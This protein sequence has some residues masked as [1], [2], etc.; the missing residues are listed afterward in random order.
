MN[1]VVR[2]DWNAFN[3]IHSLNSRDAFQKLT[4]QLFC[5]EYDQPYGIYRFYNQPYIETVPISH[6]KETIG[7]QSKYY[8]ASTTLSSKKNDLIDAIS[9]AH[10]EYP[11]L[12][13]IVFYLNK[14]PGTSKSRLQLKPK[15][16]SEIEAHGDRLGIS[17]EWKSLNQIETMLLRPELEGIRNYFFDSNGGIRQT[18][19]QIQNHTNSM[20][21]SIATDIQYKGTSIRIQRESIQF[22]SALESEKKVIIV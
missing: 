6:G 21:E 14:E 7:F 3:Y 10:K 2:V 12:T 4:E 5:F 16:I 19:S 17:V 9:D 22:D 11:S 13:K 20:F 15:Y 1:N 8:D 18:I